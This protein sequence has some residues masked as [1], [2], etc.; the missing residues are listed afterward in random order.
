[1]SPL[2]KIQL[3]DLPQELLAAEILGR[4][5]FRD[6]L[7]CS[8]VRR[9]QSLSSPKASLTQGHTQTCKLL[10]DL[11]RAT[12]ALQLKIELGADGIIDTMTPVDRSTSSAERL[13]T[14]LDRR[15]RWSSL[16]S[17]KIERI[18][19][20]RPCELYEHS[21]GVFAQTE[22]HEHGDTGTTYSSLTVFYLPSPTQS[23]REI[24]FED[25]GILVAEMT[26]DPVQDVLTLIER[27]GTSGYDSLVASS[28]RELLVHLRTL[29]TNRSHPFASKPIL[30]CLCPDTMYITDECIRKFEI[31]DDTLALLVETQNTYIR[32][33]NWKSGEVIFV[34]NF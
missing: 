4:L 25:I 13:Q 16:S 7:H 30:R 17:S 14:H 31:F 21:N 22:N 10:H 2:I 15:R 12:S 1:M 33:W 19:M 29:T 23:A 3:L 28:S 8:M 6:V 34:S 18:T 26:I 32:L 5:N 11:I 20:P 24:V 27:R 9:S